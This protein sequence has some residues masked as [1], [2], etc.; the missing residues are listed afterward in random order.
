[1]LEAEEE[2][3][4][5]PVAAAIGERERERERGEVVVVRWEM[6]ERKAKFLETGGDG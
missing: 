3:A 2:E 1:L 4:E 6:C 5:V